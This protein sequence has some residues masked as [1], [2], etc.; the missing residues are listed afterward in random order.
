[1]KSIELFSGIGGIALAAEWAGIET[2]A[3]CENEPFCQ[4]VLRKNWPNIPIF[5][6]VKIL[7]KKMLE[8]RGIDVEAIDLISG[9]FPCQPHTTVNRK[10]KGSKDERH[11]WPKMFKL[12]NEIRPSW[13]IG[14]NVAD[15]AR[16]DEHEQAH[17][18][19]ESIGY[20]TQTLLIPASSVG[21]HHRRNRTFII[22]YSDHK[23]ELQ[24][25][26]STMSIGNKRHS[27]EDFTG[28][29]RRTLPRTYWEENQ[30]P[31]CGVDDG[32]SK[33]LD[34]SR[35]KALGNAVVPQQIYPIFEAIV[36][37]DNENM[38]RERYQ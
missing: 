9:G 8:E 6:D 20:Q 29:I 2:I 23:S 22:A 11:L 3:F 34:E 7:N 35:L 24:A 32:F 38:A 27:R 4:K 26:K 25:N 28:W 15:F 33:E 12:T 19:L 14:E 10:R 18:D 37:L 13:V 31:V 17:K 16:S 36:N 1:M 30:S 21:A 5:D